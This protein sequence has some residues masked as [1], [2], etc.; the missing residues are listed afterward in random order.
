[1]STRA[2]IVI[3]YDQPQ[4]REGHLKKGDPI[5]LY[6]GCDGYPEGVYGCS[7]MLVMAYDDAVNGGKLSSAKDKP[8]AFA[9]WLI[10]K[11][12]RDVGPCESD[13]YEYFR[14]DGSFGG[15]EYVYYIIFTRNGRSSNRNARMVVWSTD[16]S[17]PLFDQSIKEWQR[18]SD[19][20]MAW[21]SIVKDKWIQRVSQTG[22]A[23]NPLIKGSLYLD[24]LYARI[25][26][27]IY[28]RAGKCPCD[29][30]L[31]RPSCISI[32]TEHEDLKR[33][34]TGDKCREKVSYEQGVKKY[35]LSL[36]SRNRELDRIIK[37]SIDEMQ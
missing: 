24:E 28:K 31:V 18:Y 15:A 11:K 5:L 7:N 8:E 10:Q 30:C 6:K 4:P 25:L 19:I 36:L 3:Q 2:N 17:Y 26:V 23:T 33:R 21:S 13:D 34:K 35:L 29:I 14:Q 12:K 9:N 27:P 1:M 37:C 16:Q 22:K 20:I 32:E